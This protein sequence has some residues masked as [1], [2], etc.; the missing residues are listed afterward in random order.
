[1]RSTVTA[2]DRILERQVFQCVQGVVVDEDADRPL[3]RQ[4]VSQSV[5]HV[6]ECPCDARCATRS[7]ARCSTSPAASSAIVSSTRKG[8]S[9]NYSGRPAKGD[10]HPEFL[11]VLVL[12][13]FVHLLIVHR[14]ALSID[15]CDLDAQRLTVR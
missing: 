13:L 10:P 15:G 5:D 7:S 12:L 6:R 1:M 3:R 11:R 9:V 8:C 14:N 4:Q 2:L